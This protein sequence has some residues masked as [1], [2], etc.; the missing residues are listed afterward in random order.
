MQDLFHRFSLPQ[1]HRKGVGHPLAVSR[2]GLQK[3]ADVT[4]LNLPWCVAECTG[5]VGKEECL[6]FG[7]DQAEEEA[8]LGV[9]VVIVIAEVPVSAAPSRARGGSANPGCCCHSP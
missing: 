4:D 9:I 2:I 8:G 3:I 5:G 6:L 1:S 7:A